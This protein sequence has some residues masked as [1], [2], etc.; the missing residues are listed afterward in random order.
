MWENAVAD[1]SVEQ[2]FG[3]NIKQEGIEVQGDQVS[4]ELMKGSERLAHMA[5]TGFFRTLDPCMAS[6]AGTPPRFVLWSY[7]SRRAS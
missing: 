7:S 6:C 5:V 4:T 3:M 2:M 1:G